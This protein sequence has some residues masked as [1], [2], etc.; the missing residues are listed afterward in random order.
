[1]TISY[2]AR[3]MNKAQVKH[4]WALVSSNL[5]PAEEEN[6]KHLDIKIQQYP[7][8]PSNKENQH[9]ALTDFFAGWAKHTRE[10]ILHRSK[11]LKMIAAG[12]PAENETVSEY[13]DYCL[14][15]PQLPYVCLS[16]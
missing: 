2:L 1:M 7:I 8:D 11:R 4:R 14:R 9:K 10:S 15:H 16:C 12:L 3:G 13:L 6:W 5:K